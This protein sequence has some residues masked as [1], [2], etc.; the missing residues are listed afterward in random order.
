MFIRQMPDISEWIVGKENCTF[1]DV[2]CLNTSKVNIL[3]SM[4]LTWC[5]AKCVTQTRSEISESSSEW[6]VIYIYL[7]A[8]FAHIKETR[9]SWGSFRQH[10][11]LCL[12]H[13]CV[14]LR[15]TSTSGYIT[16]MPWKKSLRV[17]QSAGSGSQELPARRAISAW[18]LLQEVN[19]VKA[20]KSENVTDGCSVVAVCPLPPLGGLLKRTLLKMREVFLATSASFP[21][22]RLLL[23]ERLVS[24]LILFTIWCLHA[25]RILVTII[26]LSTI[27][28]SIFLSD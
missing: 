4:R 14:F 27:S 9:H 22:T 8:S 25:E 2:T 5:G 12:A 23:A 6:N 21:K 18:M 7:F 26:L 28:L 19:C 13:R 20:H 17:Q 16:S 10:N 1:S 3:C 15:D 11:T 24:V